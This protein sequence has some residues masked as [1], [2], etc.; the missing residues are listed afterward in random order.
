MKNTLKINN[1]FTYGSKNIIEKPYLIYNYT[2]TPLILNRNNHNNKIY[3]IVI[4][5]G[6]IIGTGVAREYKLRYPK[7]SMLLIEKEKELGPF[8]ALTL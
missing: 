1:I 4:I 7:K 6:G 5:G 2:T 8:I 3:D